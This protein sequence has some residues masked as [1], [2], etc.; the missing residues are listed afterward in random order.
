[1]KLTA[2][3]AL[4]KWLRTT[5]PTDMT[6]IV[7]RAPSQSSDGVTRCDGRRIAIRINSQQDASQQVHTLLHEW[8]HALA[9]DNAYKHN[10][11]WGK[12]YSTIY[13]AWEAWDSA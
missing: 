7:R 13:A 2:W 6:V 9:L 1:M 4:L 5:F 12:L 8:G 3:R 11:A 10:E